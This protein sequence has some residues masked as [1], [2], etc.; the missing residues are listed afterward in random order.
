MN[1]LPPPP[2]PPP[3]PHPRS[4]NLRTAAQIMKQAA[5]SSCSSFFTVTFVSLLLFSFRTMVEN[6]SVYVTTFIDRDPSLKALLSRLDVDGKDLNTGGV[7]A[8]AGADVRH[9]RRPF[10]QLTRVGN[11]DDNL[12]S[13]DDEHERDRA[14]FGL[15]PQINASFVKLGFSDFAEDSGFRVS[16]IVRS[17]LSFKVEGFDDNVDHD[18]DGGDAGDG[19][20]LGLDEQEGAVDMQ[21]L[22]KGFDL[23]GRD[24][25]AL[26]FLVSFLSAAYGWAI[27]GFLVTYSW[28]LGIVCVAV[29][30]DLLG[31]YSSCLWNIW[32]GSRLGTKRLSGFILLR[33]AVRDAVTQLLGLWFFGEIEEEYSFFKLFVRL[34]LMPFSVTFPWARGSEKDTSAFLTAWFIVDFCLGFIFSL[35]SWIALA[36]SRRRG[37]HIVK[38]GFYLL[39]TMISQAVVIKCLEALFSG[40]AMRWVLGRVCGRFFACMFQSVVEAYFMVAWLLYYFAARCMDANSDGRTFGQRELEGFAEGLR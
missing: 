19:S 37:R 7:A 39:S 30:N 34:K 28:A 4:L 29:V 27:L 6:G 18:G 36:D 5:A 40:S 16:E 23:D 17:G 25:A 10:L 15:N 1:P 32:Y 21:F 9:R 11:L 31:R 8:S 14:L 3:P 13:G 2:S 35:D 24:A 33:W 22:M 38:E 26:L 12:F 20:S